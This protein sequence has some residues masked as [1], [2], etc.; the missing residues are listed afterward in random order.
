MLQVSCCRCPERRILASS[1]GA[2]A[3]S[4][5]NRIA[6][7]PTNPPQQRCI[8]H[9]ATPLR[10]SGPTLSQLTHGE[11][12]SL[13]KQENEILA[14]RREEGPGFV[15]ICAA[16]DWRYYIAAPHA[17]W[18]HHHRII[19]KPCTTAIWFWSASTL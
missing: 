13:P 8:H 9:G 1:M 2:V 15:K 19:T 12:A 3:G 14:A 4:M 16:S 17:I 18:R 6:P 7:T 10:P 11:D 5:M